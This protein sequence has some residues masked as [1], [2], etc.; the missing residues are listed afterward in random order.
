MV[1]LTAKVGRNMLPPFK[2]K[3]RTTTHLKTK[4]NQNS[5]EIELYGSLTTKELKKKHPFRLT[6]RRGGAGQLGWRG[7]TARWWLKDQVGKAVA[8]SPTFACR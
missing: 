1:G 2:T 5:Q 4:N 6:D 3:R 7:C 8:G